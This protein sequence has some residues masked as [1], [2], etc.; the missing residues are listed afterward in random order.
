MATPTFERLRHLAPSH[1]AYAPLSGVDS[2]VR[3]L[4]M[5]DVVLAAPPGDDSPKCRRDRGSGQGAIHAQEPGNDPHD[6]RS[7]GRLRPN[8][9]QFGEQA[10]EAVLKTKQLALVHGTRGQC[11]NGDESYAEELFEGVGSI[12]DLNRVAATKSFRDRVVF[13]S[14]PGQTFAEPPERYAAATVFAK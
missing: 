7:D 4:R 11:R 13:D 1:P 3:P 9:Q 6:E 8:P 14:K 10:V 12:A 2:S 5:A